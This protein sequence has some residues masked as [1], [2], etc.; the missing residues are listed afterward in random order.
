MEPQD[1]MLDSKDAQGRIKRVMIIQRIIPHYRIP[2]FR[3]LSQLPDLDLV[4]VHGTRSLD[5]GHTAHEGGLPFKTAVAQWYRISMFGLTATL[6]PGGLPAVRSFPSHVVIAEGT[7]N[8]LT[9]LLVALYC[10]LAGRKFIWWVGAWERPERRVWAR[11][12]IRG[13]TWVALKPAHAFIAYGTVARDYLIGLGVSPGKIHIAHNTIDTDE[14]SSNLACHLR[15][16]RNL[17]RELGIEGKRT[18]LSVGA[19]LPQKRVDTLI[20]AYSNVRRRGCSDIA[21]VIV[22]DGSSWK[23]LEE[24]VHCLGVEDVFFVGRIEESNPYF[25]MADLFVLPGL[26]GLALNQAMAFGKPVICS[27]ADGTERDLVIEGVN[28]HI[29]KPGD[30]GELAAVLADLLSDGERLREMGEESLRIVRE[31]INFENMVRE[32]SKAIRSVCR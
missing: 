14:I 5:S 17:K 8:I 28:G 1:K 24:L 6:Q 21:L 11:W 16:G 2:L 13:Y 3:A 22:G 26:G 9:N 15:D 29:V 7:F 10:R 4:V 12:L 25:A 18:I 20:R 30:E 31:K 19:L 23:A 32:F 27:E